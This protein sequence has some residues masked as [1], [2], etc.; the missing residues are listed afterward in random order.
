MHGQ[1]ITLLSNVVFC[2]DFTSKC[3][4]KKKKGAG[5]FHK[6]ANK[7]TNWSARDHFKCIS[8][9][10]YGFKPKTERQSIE[11]VDEIIDEALRRNEKTLFQT[12]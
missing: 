9:N 1:G 7:Q 4:K 6:Q 2:F 8:P 12:P 11:R 10:F 5:S 3:E